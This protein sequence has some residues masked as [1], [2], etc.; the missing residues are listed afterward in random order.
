MKAVLFLFFLLST[1][2]VFSQNF[3][4]ESLMK[5]L[6]EQLEI[7]DFNLESED[8]EPAKTALDSFLIANSELTAR[9]KRMEEHNDYSYALASVNLNNGGNK[10]LTS[11][12]LGNVEYPKGKLDRWNS[13]LSLADDIAFNT[14]W[15]LKLEEKGKA[16]DP[17]LKRLSKKYQKLLTRF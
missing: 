4:A 16:P 3:T 5:D 7:K 10:L 2:S 12:A 14:K 9:I 13:V 6:K 15:F 8:V 17:A 1:S 11:W